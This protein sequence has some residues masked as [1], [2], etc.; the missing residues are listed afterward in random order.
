M[1]TIIIALTLMAFGTTLA[2]AQGAPP[3]FKP[4]VYGQ[5]QVQKE[6]AKQ[7]KQ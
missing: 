4:T 1:K 2:I 6:Q 5:H 7:A 3:G